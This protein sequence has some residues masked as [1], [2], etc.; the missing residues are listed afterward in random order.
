MKS[1][2]ILLPALLVSPATMAED[3]AN[4]RY[5]F[6][7]NWPTHYALHDGTDIGIAGKYQ[8]D[9]DRFS[10]DAGQL[11]NAQTNRRKEL[12]VYVKKKGVYDATV[13]YD[14]QA[15]NWLDAFV[16]VQS[17]ALLGRDIGAFR[18]GYS[19]T[20]VGFEGN[21]G[22][23]ATTF[24][25][26][27][28]PTQAVYAGRR[29]GVDWALEQ[30]HY[31]L[32]AGYYWAGD[33]QGDSDG[34]MAAA[35]AAWVARNQADDVV[36]LGLSASRETPQGSIDGRDR[37]Q[38]P[39]ARLRARPE[40][41]LTMVRLVDTGVLGHVDYLD[42]RGF[43]GLWIAGPV[44]L[45]GEYLDAKIKR[46]SG[47]TAVHG[48]GYYAFATWTLTGESRSYSKGYAGDVKPQGRYG[49][50]E[51][52]LRYSTLDLNDSVLGGTEHNWTFGANWYLNRYLKLQANYVHAVSRR[53]DARV[54]P[55]V[56]QVRAQ[57]AF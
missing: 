15:K 17:K 49:A 28:L 29:I 55:N 44:S 50:V 45:Q 21:T 23:G 54:S 42:R 12:G 6:E 47:R 18:A 31:V 5:S 14:Y 46:Q 32:N 41:S 4:P 25:E 2:L 3:N 27:A 20:L 8:F 37:Y 11:K 36:H 22:T 57:I 30:P 26:T 1:W 52:A 38:P 51:L 48:R 40:A 39:A 7:D 56:V 19:K 10:N 9:L 34:H 33:L 35:R 43:E 13:V 53:R 16:R 24:L